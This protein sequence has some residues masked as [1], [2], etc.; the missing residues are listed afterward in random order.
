MAEFD[1]E[2]PDFDSAF[3]EE[4]DAEP[5]GL[6]RFPSSRRRRGTGSGG[7]S[8]STG[9]MPRPGRG[10]DPAAPPRDEVD[11]LGDGD[12]PADEPRARPRSTGRAARPRGSRPR[13]QAPRRGGSRGGRGGGAT[14]LQHPRARLALMGAFAAILI[15]VIVLVVRDCQRSQLEDS[16]TQYLNGVAQITAQSAEQGAQLRQIMSNP[17]GDK[18]PQLRRKIQA[19]ATSAQGLVHRAEGLNPPGTLS[20]PQRSFVTALQYRVT[21]LSTLA[22]NLP[23]L[24]QSNDQQTKAIGLA[25]PMQRFLASDVIYADSF[26]G[27]A[28]AALR[29]DGITGIEVP[30]GQQ[31]LPNPALASSAGA[32]S[33]IAGLQRRSPARGAS[34]GQAGAGNLRGT[35]LESTQALPSETR[36]TPGQ[37]Q[38]V[39]ASDQLKWRV[40]V[41]NGG[42][43]NETNVVVKV[44]FFYASNPNKVDAKEASIPSI[45]SGQTTTVDI[46]GPT[47]PV[48]GEQ[49][50]LKI[51]IVPVS[52]ETRIDNNRAE[53]PVKITI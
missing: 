31:F 48:F 27:P 22:E 53:Y 33:L 35:S 15:L 34:G 37:V 24:L 13:R 18:P 1:D 39:Q 7:D 12:G 20:S 32:A 21:G 26:V 51:E 30:K 2:R 17:R 49:G 23:A 47:T 3:S 50:T 43:F 40:T 9:Q 16:Y 8:G 5:R 41:K 14:A 42:D 10:D 28:M 52:G 6:R 38:T 25:D 29:S 19:L 44:S 36:L 4:P 11:D 46:P 45:D